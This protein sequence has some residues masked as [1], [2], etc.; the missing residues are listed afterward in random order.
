MP[1]ALEATTLASS[2]KALQLRR[3]ATREL[4]EEAYW[5]LIA[6]LKLAQLPET[7][8]FERMAELNQAYEAITSTPIEHASPALLQMQHRRAS[9]TKPSSGSN[10]N[11]Y[12]LLRIDEEATPTVVFVAVRHVA[13]RSATDASATRGLREAVARAREVLTDPSKRLEYDVRLGIRSRD[14]V[15]RARGKESRLESMSQEDEVERSPRAATPAPDLDTQRAQAAQREDASDDAPVGRAQEA[16]L[17]SPAPAS[18][19]G[20]PA[21]SAWAASLGRQVARVAARPWKQS[22]RG[23]TAPNA[24]TERLLTLRPA[25]HT[26]DD[27]S[28]VTPVSAVDPAAPDGGADLSAPVPRVEFETGPLAGTTVPIVSGDSDTD[29]IELLLPDGNG[30]QTSLRM[31]RRGDGY[32]LVHLDGPTA[33]VG[34]QEMVLPVIVLEDGDMICAGATSV[35]FMLA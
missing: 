8:R 2:Y 7:V 4:V 27:A 11:F 3:S 19:D 20:D 5:A 18:D 24:E 14:H 33:T 9:R 34:G 26:S 30:A 22:A 15:G 6:E 13:K 10:A 17:T 29:G 25:P 28:P 1:P 31:A 21:A 23:A 16:P 35:R 32:M 12:E